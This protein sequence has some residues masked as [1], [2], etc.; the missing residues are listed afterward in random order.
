M[1]EAAR[2]IIA[3]GGKPL[4]ITDCLNY[5]SPDKPEVFGN[6]RL[7]LTELLLRVKR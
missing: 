7:Q 5:G 1:A 4:A 6:Y 2:N 3:S